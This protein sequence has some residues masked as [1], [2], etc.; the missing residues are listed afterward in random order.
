MWDKNTKTIVSSVIAAG[1]IIAA[2]VIY[3]N[4]GG[5]TGPGETGESLQKIGEATIDYLNA[6]LLPPEMSASLVDVTDVGAVYKIKL[7]IQDM[8][9]DSYISKDGVYLFPEGYNMT[10]KAA[11]A[12]ANTNVNVEAPKSD[13]PDVK[14][15]VMSYCPYGLQAQKMFLP[16]YDLLKDKADMGVYF[17]N[18]IMHEKEEIDENLNQYCIQKEE[19]EKFSAYLSC[20]VVS[21]DSA[22]CLS[23]ANIN[24]AGI[25]ACVEKTDADFKVTSQYNDKSTW[26]NG[27]YPKFD[28]HT[29]L[30][31]KYGVQGSPTIVINDTVVD[32]NPR[33]PE[34]FKEVIC[35]AFNN[36]PAECSQTLSSESPVAGLGAGTAAPSTGGSCE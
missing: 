13:K 31:Q 20:F 7:A 30:N 24:K 32:V 22:A 3:V 26:L 15:F 29:D 25:S 11:A 23:Q 16:V 34:N 33:S 21:G 6:N 18:Y 36:A 27:T 19:N 2:A 28:V 35:Q 9:Y 10:E 17:V 4:R 8:E 1:V 5:I 14:I 12:G